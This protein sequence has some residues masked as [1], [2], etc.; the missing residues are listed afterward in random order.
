[1]RIVRA[2]DQIIQYFLLDS[3]NDELF[4]YYGLLVPKTIQI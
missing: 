1:M 2:Y 4:V 3:Q